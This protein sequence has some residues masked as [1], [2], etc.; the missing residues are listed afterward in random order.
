MSIN[1]SVNNQNYVIPQT[2]NTGW[3]DQVTNFI[4]AVGNPTLVLQR[5]STSFS[6]ANEV[7]FGNVAGVK[8]KSIKSQ[9]TNVSTGGVL[10]L[11]NT[12]TV[13]WR[14]AANNGDLLLGFNG[15][16]QLVING[17]RVDS[18]PAGSNTQIQYN[19]SGVFGATADLT[20][21][22]GGAPKISVGASTGNGAVVL[23]GASTFVYGT[24]TALQIVGNTLIQANA[25]GTGGL[26]EVFS[27]SGHLTFNASGALGFG[28]SPSYGSSG[29]VLT[30]AGSSA[31]PTWTTLPV[32]TVLNEQIAF[33]S[34]GDLLTGSSKFRWID[35][36]ATLYI[37]GVASN[38]NIY[39]D[40][41]GT[42]TSGG[43]LTLRTS[44]GNNMNFF[45][46]N[47]VTGAGIQFSGG[48]GS[49]GSGGGYQAIGGTG[50]TAGGGCILK[51]GLGPTDAACGIVG[52][53]T[54]TT[55][56]YGIQVL[57]SGEFR[58]NT[59]AGTAG[60]VL[61]TGGVGAPA[62]WTTI[63]TSTGI[64][65]PTHTPSSAS[66]TGTAGT[67]TWDANFMYVC[68]ATDTWKRVAIAT[69]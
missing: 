39:F 57:G 19:N 33:G 20:V 58:L 4:A 32:P 45:A 63:V 34:A 5:V 1:V 64:Q 15:L 38:S 65:V 8:L 40:E 16:D 27:Q 18:P 52:V 61:T 37:E 69:W 47:G 2:G 50:T 13:G 23:G 21:T 41:N 7:D 54:G 6:L 29:Q 56:Q 51:G 68:T 66:D 48:D 25:T 46:S 17:V 42:I 12:E 35:S 28:S 22:T 14:N 9:G 60:Q 43:S 44:N 62:S 11:A 31:T 53:L 59:S 24:N 10:R 67:V 49:G 3:G 36:T 26:F 30:S 55:Y